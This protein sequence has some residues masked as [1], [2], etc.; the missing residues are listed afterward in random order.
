MAT[1]DQI[2]WATQE[3]FGENHFSGPRQS[4]RKN[5]INDIRNQCELFS[6][7]ASHGIIELH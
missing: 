4:D 5:E 2:K 3:K 6:L 7:L 1:R